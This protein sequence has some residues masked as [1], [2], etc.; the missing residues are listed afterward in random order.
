VERPLV[1]VRSRFPSLLR[2]I[3]HEIVP[4]V[5]DDETQIAF[6]CKVNTSLDLVL[7]SRQDDIISIEAACA[8]LRR[9]GGWQAGVVRRERPQVRNWMVGPCTAVSPNLSRSSIGTL[10][11]I[12]RWPSSPVH[13]HTS[14]RRTRSLNYQTTCDRRHLAELRPGVLH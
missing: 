3:L 8:W 7:C 12:A 14:L 5:A 6:P 2:A 4:G 1:L 11:A 10:T 9:I 13:P